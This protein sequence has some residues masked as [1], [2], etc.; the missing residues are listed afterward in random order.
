MARSWLFIQVELVEGNGERFWPR[1][2]RLFAAS[3]AHSFAQLSDAIEDAFARWDRAHLHEFTLADATR[4]ATPFQGWE[5]S[6]QGPALDD[7]RIRLNRLALGERFLYIF[8]F[9]DGWLHLCTVGEK[10]IDPLETLG[11]LPS[12]PLPYWG[13]GALPDQYGRRF[14]EDDG[15]SDPPPDPGFV[16]LPPLRP[17]WGAKTGGRKPRDSM[18]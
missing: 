17:W 11:S 2:G 14:A 10:R 15:E 8:D 1:P 4:L 12:R 6:S 18:R 5:Q 16:D 7:R 9:G 13:W 3:R